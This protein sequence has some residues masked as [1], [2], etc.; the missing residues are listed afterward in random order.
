MS[1]AAPEV[2]RQEQARGHK[3]PHYFCYRCAPPVGESGTAVCGTDA[4]RKGTFGA[5]PDA[6]WVCADLWAELWSCPACGWR[7]WASAE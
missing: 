1:T 3:L 2:T 4:A 5:K 7:N 6:C